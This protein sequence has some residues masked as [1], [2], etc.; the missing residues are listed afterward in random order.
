MSKRILHILPVLLLGLFASLSAVGQDRLAKIDS[1]L[2]VLSQTKIS[3]L[4]D[5]TEFEAYSVRLDQ[6]LQTLAKAHDVNMWITTN[7]AVIPPNYLKNAPLKDVLLVLCRNYNLDLRV[8]NNILEFYPYQAPVV[9]R[10]TPAEKQLNLRYNPNRETVTFDLRND[11]LQLFA[12]QITALTGTNVMV[13][14]A[15]Q[16]KLITGYVQEQSIGEALE[17]LASTNGLMLDNQ[18]KGFY[19]FYTLAPVADASTGSQPA[20]TSQRTTYRQRATRGGS[21]NGF[22]VTL[23]PGPD[24]MLAVSAN[25]ASIWEI[26]QEACA[27]RNKDYLILQGSGNGNGASTG[28]QQSRAQI[29]AQQRAQNGQEQQLS[30]ADAVTAELSRVS[31]ND[32]FN[33]ILASTN[34]SY[35]LDKN[36]Y[37]IGDKNVSQ[38]NNTELVRFQFRSVDSVMTYIPSALTSQVETKV[39]TELNALVVSGASG[40]IASLKDYIKAID[41]PVPNILIEVIVANVQKGYDIR[42]GVSAGISDSAVATQGTLFP[43]VDV[44]LSSGSLNEILEKIEA[45]GVI[46]IG[47]VTPNVYA[48]LRAL[49]DNNFLNIRASNKLSALNGHAA[50][51]KV[52]EQQ[53]YQIQGQNVSG[54]INNFTQFTNRFETVEANLNIDIKPVVSGNEH[55]TLSISAEF[56]D[57]IPATDPDLPPGKSTREFSSS[58]RVRNGEMIVLGGL[59]EVTNANNESGLPLIS[60]IPVLKWLFSR[61]SRTQSQ[62]KLIVFI[63]PTIV[64]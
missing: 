32:L 60:R 61:T 16:D 42:T 64:Y 31:L 58:V 15:D 44:V 1:T 17:A 39:F 36:V 37:L 50:N 51:L 12:R 47:R 7:E 14:K 54:G 48:E 40:D 2:T 6:F 63:K 41:Q 28:Q 38:L 24:S 49:E 45:T 21:G 30:T 3:A 23:L 19:T 9:V 53:F 56:S 29:L 52:G 4:A 43:G 18:P 10:P 13:D 34:Y 55:I 27:V 46:N 22:Q 57:F 20:N 5:S 35:R 62:S 8:Q 33:T 11:N 25:N 59:E 26:I